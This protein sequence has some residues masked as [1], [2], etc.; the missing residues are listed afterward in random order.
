MS[1]RLLHVGGVRPSREEQGRVSMP[2]SLEEY[3]DFSMISQAEGLKFGIEHF[4]RRKPHCSGTLF[5]RQLEPTLSCLSRTVEKR[6][7]GS[8][9]KLGGRRKTMSEFNAVFGEYELNRERCA[10]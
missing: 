2:E 9:R 10:R 8:V 1:Q 6:R 4:R 5:W 7:S 3:I